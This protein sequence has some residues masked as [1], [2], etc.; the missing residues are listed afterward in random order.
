MRRKRT[1]LERF[2][3][4][5][6]VTIFGILNLVPGLGGNGYADAQYGGGGGGGGGSCGMTCTAQTEGCTYS[7]YSCSGCYVIRCDPG[8]PCYY[9]PAYQGTRIEHVCHNSQWQDGWWDAP[10]GNCFP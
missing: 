7:T 8:G 3:L 10:C 4:P 1:I 9:D 2:I 5:L 6:A